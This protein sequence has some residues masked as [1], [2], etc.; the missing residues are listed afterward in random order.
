MNDSLTKK[1]ILKSAVREI[2]LYLFLIGDSASDSEA[3]FKYYNKAVS[4]VEFLQLLDII[5][6]DK[7]ELL[8]D[9]LFT[10]YKKAFCGGI[11]S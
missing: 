2:E 10:K 4:I 9:I 1:E 8:E 11:L 5:D 6:I 7:K 3:A